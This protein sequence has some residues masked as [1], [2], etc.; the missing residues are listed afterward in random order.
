MSTL[1][2]AVM[3]DRKSD[4]EE[5]GRSFL[6]GEK[7]INEPCDTHVRASPVIAAAIAE[8]KDELA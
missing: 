6:R 7:T 4:L 2:D 8:A 3:E 1:N 5:I